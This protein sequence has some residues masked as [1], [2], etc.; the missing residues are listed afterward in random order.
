NS[1]IVKCIAYHLTSFSV[2]L[3]FAQYLVNSRILSI[4]TYVGLSISLFCLLITL[5]TFTT[6]RRFHSIRGMI[7]AN[8]AGSLIISTCIFLAGIDRTDNMVLCQIIAAILHFS[9]LASFA[10]MLVEGI[11]T[12]KMATQWPETVFSCVIYN[13]LG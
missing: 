13:V 10:W 3:Q 9:F 6:V 5:W 4:L 12:F 1:T 2:L 7:H 8:L 11:I